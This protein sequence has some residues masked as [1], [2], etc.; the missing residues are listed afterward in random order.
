MK[1]NWRRGLLLGLCLALLLS[2]GIAV[3][4][5]LFITADKACVE[6]WPG[7]EDPTEDRYWIELTYGGWA[8][9]R[10]KCFRV[11]IDGQLVQDYCPKP[12][13]ATDPYTER[14][15]FPCDGRATQPMSTLALGGEAVVHN[16]PVGPLGEWVVQ[17]YQQLATGG[18][19][20]AQVSFLVA[21]V[22]EVE[23]VP[24]PGSI[25]LLGSGLAG[26]AGYATLRWRT[27]E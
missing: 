11:W 20:S 24:E 13:P 25:L 19:D 27:R 17:V 4:Q 5:G 18:E 22:C 21:E 10:A 7:E 23:F 1:K 16:G 8:A 15:W 2:G 12:G 14:G 9:D 3:A 26:L 6:C